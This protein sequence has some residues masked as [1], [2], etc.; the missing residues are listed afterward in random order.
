MRQPCFRKNGRRKGG[1]MGG[2]REGEWGR[3]TSGIGDFVSSAG[4]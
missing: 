3:G 2:V 4:L 1:G